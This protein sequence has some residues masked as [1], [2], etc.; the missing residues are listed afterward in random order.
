[1]TCQADCWILG[2]CGGIVQSF[3]SSFTMGE[4]GHELMNH[5]SL[6]SPYDYA[7][8]EFVTFCSI[9]LQKIETGSP[10]RPLKVVGPNLAHSIW[11]CRCS[12]IGVGTFIWNAQHT[13]HLRNIYASIVPK[14]MFDERHRFQHWWKLQVAFDDNRQCRCGHFQIALGYFEIAGHDIANL[15]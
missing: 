1:M 14:S 3:R 6:P 11:Y 13:R 8:W 10:V 9:L 2:F 15:P 7:I 12:W 5:D 4:G